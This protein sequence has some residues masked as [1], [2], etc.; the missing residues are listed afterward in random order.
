MSI[1]TLRSLLTKRFGKGNFSVKADGAICLR[2]KVKNSTVDCWQIF[3]YTSD[4]LR[5]NNLR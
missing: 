3:A 5:L 1:S 4:V 2:G